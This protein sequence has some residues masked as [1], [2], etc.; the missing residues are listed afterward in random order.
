MVITKLRWILF[1]ALVARGADVSGRWRA[2]IDT[3][4]GLLK[5]VY[6][7]QAEGTS[8][9]GKA[10]VETA[11]GKREVELKESH[12]EGDTLTFVE[13]FQI[14]DREL[15]I[16]YKGQLRGEEIKFTR[17]VGEFGTEEFTAHRVEN[18]PIAAGAKPLPPRRGLAPPIV[19]GPDVK[20]VFPEPPVGFDSARVQWF[21]TGMQSG[22]IEACQTF[23]Q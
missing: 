1:A 11:E 19:L 13:I 18:P 8:L 21:K 17:K 16:E 6:I 12:I 4:I 22:H 3:P 5:Y 15:R 14:P 20:A 7:L 9:T 2:E 10:I 23:G